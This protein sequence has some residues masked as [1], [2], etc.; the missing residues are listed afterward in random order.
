MRRDKCY[1]PRF[2]RI[3]KCVK[4]LRRGEERPGN[5]RGATLITRVS[6]LTPGLSVGLLSKGDRNASRFR[7][8]MEQPRLRVQRP[9]GNMAGDS[10]L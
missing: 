4:A 5:A 6:S 3:V 1:S 10:S 8:R 7:C 2:S 9:G